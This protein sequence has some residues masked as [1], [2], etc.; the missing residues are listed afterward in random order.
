VSR[1]VWFS[2]FFYSLFLLFATRVSLMIYVKYAVGERR[3]T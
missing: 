2:F 3:T 1:V